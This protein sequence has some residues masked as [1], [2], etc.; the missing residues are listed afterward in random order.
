MK[1][2][3]SKDQLDDILDIL[4]LDEETAEKY[5]KD[6]YKDT[7]GV[8]VVE[9][10]HP[11]WVHN[12]AIEKDIEEE[13][14]KDIEKVVETEEDEIDPGFIG[15]CY[16]KADDSDTYSKIVPVRAEGMHPEWVHDYVEYPNE[17]SDAY[18]VAL[19]FNDEKDLK[20]FLKNPETDPAALDVASIKP[21][22]TKDWTLLGLLGEDT[23][24]SLDRSS[25]VN[26]AKELED[27]HELED[28]KNTKKPVEILDRSIKPEYYNKGKEDLINFLK[29]HNSQ[30]EFKGF[31]VGN[32]MK[33]LTRLGKK[34]D[35]LQDLD[36]A[37]EYLKRYRKCLTD[38]Q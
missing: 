15:V 17:K 24:N 18:E 16:F 19:V 5:L 34:D 35:E 22:D 29:D 8:E 25:L 10:T 23:I 3:I 20:E 1:K 28:I 7:E 4:G 13:C 31:M 27:K 6:I 14:L 38:N 30:E 9:D 11:E 36:K 12:E 32:A 26:K 33:Y 2:E 37:I 21:M